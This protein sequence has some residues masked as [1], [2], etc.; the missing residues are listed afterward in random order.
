MP[1]LLLRRSPWVRYNE[2]KLNYLQKST[3][4]YAVIFYP[5]AVQ[6]AN[7]LIVRLTDFLYSCR[8]NSLQYLVGY[9]S[10]QAI[11]RI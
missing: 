8:I 3:L 2:I 1:D 11:L 10:G 5:A 7:T 6:I 9:L 4:F